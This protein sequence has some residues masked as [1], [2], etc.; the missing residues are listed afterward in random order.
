MNEII[1]YNT[2]KN[3]STLICQLDDSKQNHINTNQ[4]ISL[5]KCL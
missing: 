4:I 2:R 1:M 3:K 5:I